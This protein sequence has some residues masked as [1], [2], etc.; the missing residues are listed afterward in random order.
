MY[1]TLS[2]NPKAF[3]HLVLKL[4]SVRSWDL[5]L[6][7]YTLPKLTGNSQNSLELIVLRRTRNLSP[8]PY[9]K[10]LRLKSHLLDDSLWT[11]CGEDA[12]LA[13]GL[14]KYR[15]RLP[16]SLETRTLACFVLSGFGFTLLDLGAM[17]F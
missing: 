11:A 4:K 16:D 12:G 6:T 7:Q 15:R 2:P 17:V 1:K 9:A 5:M 3:R 8:R 13:R 10:V 14:W